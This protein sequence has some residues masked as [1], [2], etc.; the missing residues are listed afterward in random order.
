ML[1]CE[2]VV[3]LIEITPNELENYLK[4]PPPGFEEIWAQAIKENPDPTSLVPFPIQGFEQLIQRQKKQQAIVNNQSLVL[5]E[6]LERLKSLEKSI[7]NAHNK[8]NICKH[9]QKQL[10]FRYFIKKKKINSFIHF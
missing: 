7:C 2:K 10:S 5:K 1:N 6:L 3:P 9:T 8:Y 4:R